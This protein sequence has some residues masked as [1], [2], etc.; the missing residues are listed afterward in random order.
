MKKGLNSV[1]PDLFIQDILMESRSLSYKD[2][3][4]ETS[5]TDILGVSEDFLDLENQN[6]KIKTLLKQ[7]PDLQLELKEDFFSILRSDLRSRILKDRILLPEGIRKRLDEDKAVK[8]NLLEI[9]P[10]DPQIKACLEEIKLKKGQFYEIISQIKS[11]YP[12]P[13]N[14]RSEKMRPRFIAELKNQWDYAENLIILS[15]LYH[16]GSLGIKVNANNLQYFK[17]QLAI[18]GTKKNQILEWMIGQVQNER[19]WQ[20]AVQELE[21]I[22]KTYLEKREALKKPEEEKKKAEEPVKKPELP[23]PS[24]K[25]K[26]KKGKKE[27]ERKQLEEKQEESK[28]EEPTK[29][30]EID[31]K[32]ENDLWHAFQDRYSN[33]FDSI[34]NLC[35]LKNI[36]FNE[37]DPNI[38]LKEFF[39]ICK[40]T[41]MTFKQG[42]PVAFESPYHIIAETL[43]NKCLFLLK[44]GTYYTFLSK[45]G[46]QNQTEDINNQPSTPLIN[47]HSTIEGSNQLSPPGLGRSISCQVEEKIDK[48]KLENFRSWIDSY[49]KWKVWQAKSESQEADL[50]NENHS[51]YHSIGS[52]LCSKVKIEDLEFCLYKQNHRCAKRIQG[53]RL[54]N[55]LYDRVQGTLLEKYVLGIQTELFRYDCLRN[56]KC[57][58]K[59]LKELFNEPF[60]NN[61]RVLM[62]NFNKKFMKMEKISLNELT[63]EI[64]KV[65]MG[66]K[67]SELDNTIKEYLRV[68]Y[69]NLVEISSIISTHLNVNYLDLWLDDQSLGEEFFKNIMKLSLFC[70]SLGFLSPNFE[71]LTLLTQNLNQLIWLLCCRIIENIREIRSVSK[72]LTIILTLIGKEYG[73]Y[74][75]KNLINLRVLPRLTDLA[76]NHRL[77][78]L[79]SLLYNLFLTHE[80]MLNKK[81]LLSETINKYASI[82]YQL[83]YFLNQPSLVRLLLKSLQPI[84]AMIHLESLPSVY[85]MN[86]FTK[87]ALNYDDLS[88]N[89]KA[90]NIHQLINPMM[91]VKEL[92]LEKPQIHLPLNNLTLIIEKIGQAI[93][94]QEDPKSLRNVLDIEI[95]RIT[96]DLDYSKSLAHNLAHNYSI[97]SENT[98]QDQFSFHQSNNP[99]LS[100]MKGSQQ[101]SST[102]SLKSASESIN[103]KASK[104]PSKNKDTVVLI[105]LSNEEDISF[106]VT[107]FYYWEELY[108][109][110]SL[111]YPKSLDEF[112]RQKEEKLK[113][114]NEQKLTSI[115]NSQSIE[116]CPI[117]PPANNIPQPTLSSM[118]SHKIFEKLI[119]N[120]P[121]FNLL[122]EEESELPFGWYL[123]YMGI[124]PDMKCPKPKSKQGKSKKCVKKV[125]ANTNLLKL[126]RKYESLIKTFEEIKETD[127]FED[128]LQTLMARNYIARMMHHIK[129]VKN[130]AT[131]LNVFG[132]A[133]ALIMAMPQKRATELGY[134]IHLG[135]N[136]L[137]KPIN[138]EQ[139]KE[140]I[141]KKLD[142][143]VVVTAPPQN[144]PQ[145]PPIQPQRSN[146]RI[147]EAALNAPKSQMVI[148][149]CD[150]AIYQNFD[151]TIDFVTSLT[152]NKDNFYTDCNKF[153]IVH[154]AAKSGSS[155]C[156]L[157]HELIEYLRFSAESNPIIKSLLQKYLE[158]MVETLSREDRWGLLSQFDKNVYVGLCNII[159]GWTQTLRSGAL[160]S[161][162]NLDRDNLCIVTQGGYTSGKKNCN[163]ISKND[164]SLLVQ[165]VNADQL[166][167]RFMNE[168][169]KKGFELNYAGLLESIRHCFNSF[170]KSKNN[171][172]DEIIS[173][174]IILRSLLQIAISADWNILIS[175]FNLSKD[176]LQTLMTFLHELCQNCPVDKSYTYHEYAFANAW[177]KLVDK[178]D[179]SNQL[180]SIPQSFEPS[181]SYEFELEQKKILV[182]KPSERNSAEVENSLNYV[183]PS[184]TYVDSLPEHQ[185]TVSEHK[186]LKYWEKHII[187]RIQDFVRSS[188]KPWEFED[189]FEQLRQPLRKGDQAKAAEVAYI[190][191]DQRLPAGV[192]LPDVNHDWNT[193]TIEEVQIGQWAIAK[194]HGTN[195]QLFSQFFTSQYRLGNTELCVQMLA[196]DA[197][198][199]SVLVMYQDHEN[200]QLIS[201][202]LPVFCLK[203]PEIPLTPHVACLEYDSIIEE[204]LR[205][206]NNSISLLSRQVLLKFFSIEGFSKTVDLQKE[207]K[208]LKQFNLPL[209]EII[210]W[211]VLEELS[212]DPVEGW[213]EANELNYIDSNPFNANQPNFINLQAILQNKKD[214]KSLKLNEIQ[215][216]LNWL[217]QNNDGNNNEHIDNLMVWLKTTFPAICDYISISGNYINLYKSSIENS[218]NPFS[219]N[220]FSLPQHL[221]DSISALCVSFKQD[222]TLCLC[223][224]LKF[225]SDEYGINIIHHIQA[226]KEAKT[227][228]KPLMFKMSNVWCSY[229]YN[230]EALPP[231]L[232][233]QAA[234]T[235]PALI[236][237]IPSSWSVCCWLLDSLSTSF[238]LSSKKQSRDFLVELVKI[239]IQGLEKLKSPVMLRELLSKLLI[240]TIRKIH[241]V[242]YETPQYYFNEEIWKGPESNKIFFELQGVNPEFVGNLIDEV[243]K[244]RENQSVEL[245]ILHSSYIQQLME[246]VITVLL[247]YIQHSELIKSISGL[248][249][250]KANN[251]P[252]G[253]IPLFNVMTICNYIRGEGQLS[254]DLSKECMDNI[255]LE[256]QW[257]RLIYIENLPQQWTPEYIITSLSDIITKNKG[258]VLLPSLDLYLPMDPKTNKHK[259]VCIILLDGW[260]VMDIEEVVSTEKKEEPPVEVI[261]QEELIEEQKDIIPEEKLWTCEICTLE[262]PDELNICSICEA[263]RPAKKQP[264]VSEKEIAA[265]MKRA[266][267]SEVEKEIQKKDQLRFEKFLQDINSFVQKYYDD[268][269]QEKE[270]EKNEE[271]KAVAVEEVKKPVEEVKLTPQELNHKRNKDAKEK[272]KQEKLLKKQ[273]IEK[274]KQLRKQQKKTKKKQHEEENE[275]ESGDE[276]V[277]QPILTENQPISNKPL[278][279]QP[280][281]ENKPI[282]NKPLIENKPAENQPPIENKPV[283]N[284]APIENKQ[285]E[286]QPPIENKPVE[287]N[288]IKPIENDNKLIEENKSNIIEEKPIN[289]IDV[290]SN[291]PLELKEENNKELM[292]EELKENENVINNS[293]SPL[294]KKIVNEDNMIMS[295]EF[296]KG[297]A[298]EEFPPP[299]KCL[300]LF[301]AHIFENKT[302]NVY[303]KEMLIERAINENTTF[304]PNILKLLKS[305]YIEILVKHWEKG[306]KEKLGKSAS[307]INMSSFENFS[308]EILAH[309]LHNPFDFWK[310]LEFLGFDFWGCNAGFHCLERPQLI[311]LRLL[312]DL[313]KYI[314]IELC[315]ETK[316]VLTFSALNI[317]LM[318]K[319]PLQESSEKVQP[320]NY[321]N[322]I[323]LESK[324]YQLYRYS[325]KD[326]RYAWSLLKIFNANLI[327]T[328]SFVNMKTNDY[329]FDHIWLSLS[330]YLSCLRELWMMPIKREL[331]HKV[332]QK[333]AVNREEVPKVILERLKLNKESN[334][335]VPKSGISLKNKD[336]FI[337]TKSFEQLKDIS[338]TLLRP[339]KPQGAEPHISFEVIF[340]GENVMGEAGPYRQYFADISMELQPSALNPYSITKNLNLLCPSPNNDAKL[341]KGRDKFVINPSA[342]SSYHLQLFEFLGILM[343]CSVRTGTHLTLDLPLLFWKQLVGQKVDFEDLEEVDESLKDLLN[344]FQNYSKAQFEETIMETF[345]TTLS[346]KTVVELKKGG[347]KIPVLYEDRYDYVHRVLQARMKESMLQIE[348]I[349]KGLT[350]LIPLPFLNGISA[351]DLEIWV[352]G[353]PKV[354]IDL[355]KRHTRYAGELNEESRRVKFLWEVLSG[356]KENE[357]LRFVKFCWGQERLPA[358][359]EEFER[360]QTRF[361][362]KPANYASNNLDKALPR[363]DTCFFNLELPDYSTKEVKYFSSMCLFIF[364]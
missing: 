234:T 160:T 146:T 157:I 93:L 297:V 42:S 263:P 247:P 138:L 187:P 91:L 358:N 237:G 174:S 281:I 306:L 270:K 277:K 338:T 108:P 175:S 254:K 80:N 241:H 240:R 293:N 265:Q 113:R 119:L 179:P 243:V 299:K 200:L 185:Q 301:G 289:K 207:E 102:S 144:P 3:N 60:L 89:T 15:F 337:F 67:F 106:L 5:L 40:Q 357:K 239:L 110:F 208:L 327:P 170:R 38:G 43:I 97:S 122:E 24:S 183:L 339:L 309:T 246:L 59:E 87:L 118:Y 308:T 283:E 221:N 302:A 216:F 171:K 232:Q 205:C 333:T 45:D 105:Q 344:I 212:E 148:S 242:L 218:N 81:N 364:I 64:N 325:I 285:V 85:E 73:L 219:L 86:Y 9:L 201:I 195:N 272:K 196:V 323:T 177:E 116:K 10:C 359:D 194:I 145:N 231:Y 137:L 328:M 356:L 19:E 227:K 311:S 111:K 267:L 88:K 197:K 284:Q 128:K 75:G 11:L 140:D 129:D 153:S 132:F 66:G 296:S 258:R 304:K 268:K 341:G 274:N 223:S 226:G 332:L 244:L 230:S 330:A 109:S 213:L 33:N 199:S 149:M 259:G 298:P 68:L 260:A 154:R 125:W 354:N 103:L 83:L 303:L 121:D 51:S 98:M 29:R 22:Q 351:K 214:N 150:Q 53:L 25:N 100:S 184:S 117:P 193:I 340:K 6:L 36:P 84:T 271:N 203:L 275:E 23:L 44:L 55:E 72:I 215:V 104:E 54:L 1:N 248:L 294:I 291:L 120:Q 352:S 16:N 206:M 172:S 233:N 112:Y 292:K 127:S 159:G 314:E 77:E 41:L 130:I 279:N 180:F 348:A 39:S 168:W 165:T 70:R 181:Q 158:E 135:I 276:E 345:S 4:N 252:E 28:K 350:I 7:N 61:L 361:M 79:L 188:L 228:L 13:N 141:R 253:F 236:S 355:L 335:P 134:I 30:P 26:K 161:I 220:T 204:F 312:S 300:V 151:F 319:S 190:L 124:F 222:A 334:K 261:P 189:F 62:K 78:G 210:R 34:R 14:L 169:E 287:N 50:V 167:L 249:P 255:K 324:Y 57:A 280:L 347:S 313:M 295:P 95:S 250:E 47:K 256:T 17:E 76:T 8:Q 343:G 321:F 32:L 238:M 320:I 198:S 147:L 71:D 346:N 264:V 96:K 286:I 191:C 166:E 63:V 269:A 56:I 360:T 90:Q 305:I 318:N 363:A 209:T 316:A 114:E 143:V 69:L 94:T 353:K 257:D 20:F 315:Q 133:P 101:C 163:I 35:L 186:M 278:E 52:F 225:Y 192:V 162:K 74:E 58:S 136:N 273:E 115:A 48:D 182:S 331:S 322:E 266:D 290:L 262:N 49:Q 164:P 176:L 139:F 37:E 178:L 235:L 12:E 142:P 317:R 156:S 2:S 46:P 288:D 202:W 155:N 245:Y 326:L 131:M 152:A 229:Y 336:D 342:K 310:I 126:E 307:F 329:S 282:E 123:N 251:L 224:G 349:K 99:P 217:V 21:E 107:V 65:K 173:I 27:E 92:M 82:L 362:V 31:E 211:S 18:I